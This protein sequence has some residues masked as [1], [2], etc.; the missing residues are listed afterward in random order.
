MFR[1]SL[2]QS[3]CMINRISTSLTVWID[4]SWLL[5][6]LPRHKGKRKKRLE[7]QKGD[8]HLSM[9]NYYL[10]V[11]VYLVQTNSCVLLNNYLRK[12][13]NLIFFLFSVIKWERRKLWSMIQVRWNKLNKIVL[14]MT[15]SIMILNN[16]LSN[17][18]NV[19]IAHLYNLKPLV[20]SVHLVLK[21][22]IINQQMGNM[23]EKQRNGSQ[24]YQNFL[25]LSMIGY[26]RYWNMLSVTKWWW[27]ILNYISDVYI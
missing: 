15:K 10:P 23:H 9:L 26:S 1:I 16:Y 5:S 13:N 8:L 6:I 3:F 17:T 2:R 25:L 12:L 7:P 24:L 22:Q 14:M 21:G 18:S 20:M 27:K 4:S 11:F 19:F